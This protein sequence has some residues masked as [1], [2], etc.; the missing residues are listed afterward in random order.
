MKNPLQTR[1]SLNH[2]VSNA[3]ADTSHAAA[4]MLVEEIKPG[5]ECC[6]HLA[7]RIRSSCGA[8]S[9]YDTWCPPV[10]SRRCHASVPAAA[11]R[12][13]STT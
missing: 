4:S 3:H 1:C 2:S 8:G 10:R 5:P 12:S 6:F 9:G 13:P 11:A 7:T